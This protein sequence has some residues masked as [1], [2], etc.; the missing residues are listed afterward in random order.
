MKLQIKVDDEDRI[1]D[2]KFKTFGC[3]SAIASSSVLTEMIK[4]KTLD[5]AAKIT[6]KEIADQLGGLGFISIQTVIGV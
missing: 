2:A 4:G 1:V 6:N 5:E 3:A